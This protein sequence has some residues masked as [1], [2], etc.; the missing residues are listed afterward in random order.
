MSFLADAHDLGGL[1]G[2]G[3]DLLLQLQVV[4]GLVVGVLVVGAFAFLFEDFAEF[5]EGFGVVAFFGFEFV[6]AHFVAS[7]QGNACDGLQFAYGFEFFDDAFVLAV[8]ACHVEDFEFLVHGG[9]QDRGKCG[10][11]FA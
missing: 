10:D 3:G 11:G 7:A 9:W 4:V 6:E 1:V 2:S 5:H 8:G